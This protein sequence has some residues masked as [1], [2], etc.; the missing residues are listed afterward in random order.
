VVLLTTGDEVLSEKKTG[1]PV[2]DDDDGDGLKIEA[3]FT[4]TGVIEGAKGEAEFEMDSDE[5]EFSV[6]IKDVPAGLYALDVD[7]VNYGDIEVVEDDGDFEGKLKFSD[8]Q[9]GDSLEL[10][11]DPRGQLI[12]VRQNDAEGTPVIL[13]VLFPSE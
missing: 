7:G 11:F 5:T 4:N 6:K 3:D 9:E 1:K 12:E 8:P 13:E 2:D 10:L